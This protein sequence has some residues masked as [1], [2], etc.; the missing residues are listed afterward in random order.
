MLSVT[1]MSC[2]ALSLCHVGLPPKPDRGNQ[3][4]KAEAA[5]PSVGAQVGAQA[6]Q[7]KTKVQQT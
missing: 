6:A 1:V 3:K 2:H 5:E 4:G 7:V